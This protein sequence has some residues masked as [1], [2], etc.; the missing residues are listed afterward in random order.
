MAAE[1]IGIEKEK[2]RK[3]DKKVSDYLGIIQPKSEWNSSILWA[4][5]DLYFLSRIFLWF[6]YLFVN[7]WDVFFLFF[8]IIFTAYIYSN[9]RQFEEE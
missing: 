9:R 6:W 8:F 5:K 7:W 3:W 1:F 2:L 4:L